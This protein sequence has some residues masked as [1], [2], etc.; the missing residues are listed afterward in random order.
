VEKEIED[1]VKLIRYMNMGKKNK[2]VL[3][4]NLKIKPWQ[5]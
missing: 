4:K 5:H 3:I 1:E 2:I